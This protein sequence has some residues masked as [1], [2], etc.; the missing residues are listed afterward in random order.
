MEEEITGRIENW[1]FDS[2]CIWGNLYDDVHKRWEEGTH[3]YTS[4]VVS[5]KDNIKEGEVVKTQNSKYLLGKPYEKVLN[6]TLGE[7]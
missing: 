2:E 3:V 1:V 4:K 7:I 5:P 6:K